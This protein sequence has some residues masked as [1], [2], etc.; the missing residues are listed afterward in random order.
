MLQTTAYGV[1]GYARQD[2]P[3]FVGNN[4]VGSLGLEF[5]ADGYMA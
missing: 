1:E 5:G 2:A 3:G 4:K